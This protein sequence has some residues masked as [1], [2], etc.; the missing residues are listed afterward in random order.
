MMQEIFPG[1]FKE[2][3]RLYTINSAKDYNPFGEELINKDKKQFRNW[4]PNRSKAAAAI[5]KGISE[6][7]IKTGVKVLYL[8]AAHGY[9]ISFF[10]N[11]VG[12]DGIL[13]GVEFSERCFNEFMPLSEKY[14]NIVPICADARKTEDY[15]WIEAVDVVYEDVAQIDQVQI[16]IRNAEQFLKPKG[17]A[18]LALKTRSIDVTKSSKDISKE[19][20]KILEE[21][22]DIIDWKM[23]DPYEKG[24]CL[25]VMRKRK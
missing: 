21:Y 9:T 4:D 16:L 8:G 24:H 15:A 23:L 3:N 18:I 25:I 22:F 12:K 5:A 20:I 7:P 6:F 13:Y 17:Y 19:A 2:G 14:K 1:V 10:S 11:I